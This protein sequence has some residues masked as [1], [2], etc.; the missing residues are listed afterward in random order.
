VVEEPLHSEK[1]VDGFSYSAMIPVGP[2]HPNAPKLD[3]NKATQCYIKRTGG[4]AG[5]TKYFGPF[6]ILRGSK[7]KPVQLT[8]AG[9][10]Q[11]PRCQGRPKTWS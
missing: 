5:V 10:R 4:F 3:P 11:D 1:H 7:P 9:Q 6:D 2:L 8:E